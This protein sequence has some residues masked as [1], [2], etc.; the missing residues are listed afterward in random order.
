MDVLQA[1]QVEWN[2]LE[3]KQYDL[4]IT[5]EDADHLSNW[6]PVK[7]TAGKCFRL[8]I[9][10]EKPGLLKN[11]KDYE[12]IGRPGF[13]LIELEEER[14]DKLMQYLGSFLE[15]SGKKELCL[16]V[17]YTGMSKTWYAAIINYLMMSD[18]F[19]NKITIYF[20]YFPS[21][22]ASV[23]KRSF[24]T[25]AKPLLRSETGQG[26]DHNRKAL[27]VGLGLDH[28]EAERLV[29]KID[30]QVLYLFYAEP[31]IDSAYTAKV[32]QL[33]QKVIK[34]AGVGNLVAYPIHDMEKTEEIISSLAF[35]LRLNHKVFLAPLGGRILS[36]TCLL[37]FSKFPDIEVW[38]TSKDNESIQEELPVRNPVVLET[39]FVKE[40][41]SE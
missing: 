6:L 17:D 35:D 28:E 36:L 2:D 30:P 32:L 1:C 5:S 39:I 9:K 31:G 20:A 12:S 3:N 23:P 25:T 38:T 27:L 40:E 34:K 14:S 24:L 16:L 41:E 10:H 8:A 19:C 29:K 33:N 7:D 11:R 13:E 26:K 18:T 21:R 15:R 4:V 37:I 22:S